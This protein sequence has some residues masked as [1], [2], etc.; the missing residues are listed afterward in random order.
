MILAVEAVI[1]GGAVLTVPI[2]TL[3]GNWIGGGSALGWIASGPLL[4]VVG[5]LDLGLPALAIAL[6]VVGMWVSLLRV[7]CGQAVAR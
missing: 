6:P 2:W 7:A 5:Q 1:V 4:F 3:A